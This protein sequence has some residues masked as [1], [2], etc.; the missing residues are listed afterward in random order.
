MSLF[1]TMT[2]TQIIDKIYEKYE[3]TVSKCL[4][5]DVI[6][7]FCIRLS[8]KITEEQSVSIHNFGTFALQSRSEWVRYN[9]NSRERE[10]VP[11]KETIK[12]I[13]HFNFQQLRK[14]VKRKEWQKK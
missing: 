3:G 4:I 14:Q 1:R 2:K 10:S 8:T 5:S 11:A 6:D 12:F 9:P 7:S 13:P